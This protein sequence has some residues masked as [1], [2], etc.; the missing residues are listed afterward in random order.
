MSTKFDEL[1]DSI[2]MIIYKNIPFLWKQL[3]KPYRGQM[4]GLNGAS[5]HSLSFSPSVRYTFVCYFF[6]LGLTA[7]AVE[8]ILAD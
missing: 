7:Q 2:T 3:Q 8:W 4:S 6:L 5:L 1:V